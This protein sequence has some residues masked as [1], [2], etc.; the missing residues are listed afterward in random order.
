MS[1]KQ[2]PLTKREKNICLWIWGCIPIDVVAVRESKLFQERSKEYE[3]TH[4]WKWPDVE[5]YNSLK[6]NEMMSVNG[7]SISQKEFY[8][9]T[10]AHITESV[11]NEEKP[12]DIFEKY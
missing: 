1:E 11:W 3:S 6:G 5:W 12:F 2:K 7:T 9:K 10:Y 8:S 4:K